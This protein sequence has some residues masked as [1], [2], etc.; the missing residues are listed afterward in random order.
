MPETMSFKADEASEAVRFGMRMTGHVL[1]RPDGQRTE[2]DI[3]AR[4][5]RAL[6]TDFQRASQSGRN[7]LVEEVPSGDEL[8]L[9]YLHGQVIGA[10]VMRRPAGVADGNSS[11]LA[12]ARRSPDVA[13]GA[14]LV[15]TLA[16][17]GYDLQDVPPG[18][19][20]FFLRD[21]PVRTRR[22]PCPVE[23]VHPSFD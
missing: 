10:I 17:Q 3:T 14:E 6:A 4:T 21:L 12:I 18:G 1:V 20:T 16:R 9:F 19:A 15:S 23:A 2:S 11:V 22:K 8:R 13:I 5:R 7:V